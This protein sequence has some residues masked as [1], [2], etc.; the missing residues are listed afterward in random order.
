MTGRPAALTHAEVALAAG[1]LRLATTDGPLAQPPDRQSLPPVRAVPCQTVSEPR[2]CAV[3]LSRCTPHVL[4]RR[5]RVVCRPARRRAQRATAR[6]RRPK[7]RRAGRTTARR[8]VDIGRGRRPVASSTSGVVPPAALAVVAQK[9]RACAK[10][11][12]TP[13][14]ARAANRIPGRRSRSRPPVLARRPRRRAHATARRRGIGMGDRDRLPAARSP[15]SW[16]RSRGHRVP[17]VLRRCRPARN[18]PACSRARRISHPSWR[19]LG[20]MPGL[21]GQPVR[22]GR[23]ATARRIDDRYSRIAIGR[24]RHFAQSQAGERGSRRVCGRASTRWPAA[25]RAVHAALMS[26]SGLA[27]VGV[28]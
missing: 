13:V 15:L 18:T 1:A 27:V 17:P 16:T 4:R 7:S 23:R 24:R 6:E 2:A 10:C 3:R 21:R 11:G 14:H 9:A 25:P 22:A 19:S 26:G 8:C 5:I 12:H 28:C 20:G